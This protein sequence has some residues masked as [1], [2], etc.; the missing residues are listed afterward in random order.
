MRLLG[1]SAPAKTTEKRCCKRAANLELRAVGNN[2]TSCTEAHISPGEKT[3]IFRAG[4]TQM[5]SILQKRWQLELFYLSKGLHKNVFFSEKTNLFMKNISQ[6]YFLTLLSLSKIL[7][8]YFR[9]L[10]S[11]QEKHPWLFCTVKCRT[12]LLHRISVLRFFNSKIRKCIFLVFIVLLVF[13]VLLS[14]WMFELLTFFE[15]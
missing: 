9:T 8:D 10:L 13:W 4:K 2:K 1:K 14:I 6:L 12:S 5:I 11:L 7:C 3:H 15:L